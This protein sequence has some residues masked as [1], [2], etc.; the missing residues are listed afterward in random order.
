VVAGA[1]DVVEHRQQAPRARRLIARSWVSASVAVDAALVVDVFGIEAL[2]VVKPL[3]RQRLGLTR[4]GSAP[5]CRSATGFT[6]GRSGVGGADLRYRPGVRLAGLSRSRIRD[7]WPQV[8][9]VTESSKR[10]FGASVR[11]ESRRR[12]AP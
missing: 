6:L 4:Q 10:A 1:L 2:Q 11:T 3:S 12:A 5:D 8:G 7:R 9:V